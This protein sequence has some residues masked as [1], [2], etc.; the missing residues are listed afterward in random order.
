[1]AASENMAYSKQEAT[2]VPFGLIPRDHY[3]AEV[4]SRQWKL[5]DWHSR[6]RQYYNYRTCPNESW[7]PI[8]AQWV[9]DTSVRVLPLISHVVYPCRTA[10]LLGMTEEDACAVVYRASNGLMLMKGV[11]GPLNRGDIA[12]AATNDPTPGFR[13]IVLNQ[14]LLTDG[15]SAIRLR[16]RSNQLANADWREV[17]GRLLQ[18]RPSGN[19]PSRKCIAYRSLMIFLMRA[20]KQVLGWE[21]DWEEGGVAFQVL[22]T[23]GTQLRASM[24]WTLAALIP[25]LEGKDKAVEAVAEA[26]GFEDYDSQCSVDSEKS[27]AQRLLED[28][29][30][31]WR[32][33]LDVEDPAELAEKERED[34]P[35]R[36]Q[37]DDGRFYQ[38]S[39]SDW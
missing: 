26:I 4:K 7:D 33:S 11:S 25:G 9:L 36:Y 23:H 34:Y 13:L 22:S 6:C 27:N 5:W 12:I 1:M 2:R 3:D 16:P 17:N 30:A 14:A 15:H 19:I 29:S 18:F 31:D 10:Y 28:W 24:I 38:D 8:L 32:E 39:D 20:Y 21:K 35:R 37:P